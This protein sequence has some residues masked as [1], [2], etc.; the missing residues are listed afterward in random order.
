MR[1]KIENEWEMLSLARILTYRQTKPGR[2]YILFMFTT[3][4]E[5]QNDE[6]LEKNC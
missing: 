4:T 1:S 3:K 2:F 6:V 5:A